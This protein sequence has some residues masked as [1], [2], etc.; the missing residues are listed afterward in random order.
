MIAISPA[1]RPSARLPSHFCWRGHAASHP[2][3]ASRV[4][5][6][7]EPFADS[8][9]AARRAALV[10]HALGL[11]LHVLAV[12]ALHDDLAGAARFVNLI[13]NQIQG[14]LTLDVSTQVVPG[15]VGYEGA[16]AA[17]DAALVVVPFRERRMSWFSGSAALRMQRRTG[18][19]ILAVRL[20][21]EGVYRRAI[22]AVTLDPRSRSLIA[23]ARALNDGEM[24]VMHVLGSLNDATMRLAD[25]TE[26][27][28]RERRERET[29][30]THRT[31]ADL[32]ASAGAH[33][34]HSVV[35]VGDPGFELLQR[36]T[37]THA[38]L[39]VVGKQTRAA[40][41]DALCG[42][43]AQRVLQGADAD[44]LVVPTLP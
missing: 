3:R 44:I 8:V 5:A 38:D 17:R 24:E 27:V 26:R 16:Q 29:L 36:Q 14:D 19:P 35:A 42:S 21:A 28:I 30:N 37:A 15:T 12:P 41:L 13:A 7:A 25:V 39:L 32:I 31:L 4:V 1:G 43:V 23:G 2:S 10:A 20:P 22:A 34:A 33:S 40:W 11:R 18:R 9:N 6:F